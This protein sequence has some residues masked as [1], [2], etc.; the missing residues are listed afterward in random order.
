MNDL[1]KFAFSAAEGFDEAA[2]R[3]AFSHAVALKTIVIYCYDPRATSIPELVAEQFGDVYPGEVVRN[4]KGEK[5]A[6][7]AT[8]FP[9][10]VAGGRAFDAL[11]SIAVAQHLF[12][13]ENIVVVHHSYCGATTFTAD[14]IIGAFR[15]EHGA[16]I[17]HA[18]PRD[19]LC[20]SDYRQSL[21]SDVALIRKQP[22]TPEAANVFGYFYDIDSDEI[23]L[24]VTSPGLP[25]SK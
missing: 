1:A 25:R 24:V 18:F 21:Q 17:A 9:V 13:I 14:G 7:T 10:I 23:A 22:G 3:E 5:V 6:S 15:R 16:D 19:A 4:G 20:I 2:V 11:R 12:G 8:I